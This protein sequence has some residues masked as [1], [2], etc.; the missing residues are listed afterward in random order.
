MKEDHEKSDGK[1]GVPSLED[2]L[3]NAFLKHDSDNNGT[4]STEEF[5]KLMKELQLGLSDADIEWLH[6]VTD[7]DADNSV[8]LDEFI[9]AAPNYFMQLA[10]TY[11]P[12]NARD[13]CELQDDDGNI[14]Y[15]NKRTG[16]SSWEPPN[17][18]FQVGN[19]VQ[20]IRVKNLM[21]DLF[22]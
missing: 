15:Y 11:G 6:S 20:Q 21:S 22:I 16:E 2:Y 1:G 12:S 18:W 13:W 3:K 5:W 19:K 4:L 8:K 10:S 14:Y 7:A 9:A 17:G